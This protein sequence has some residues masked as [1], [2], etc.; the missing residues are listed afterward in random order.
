MKFAIV[1]LAAGVAAL[2]TL[3]VVS[4]QSDLFHTSSLA[5]RATTASDLGLSAQL[6]RL[7][8]TITSTVVH[9]FA[10]LDKSIAKIVPKTTVLSW[11]DV[12]NA[13]RTLDVWQ[14]LRVICMAQLYRV[15][16]SLVGDLNA[17]SELLGVSE[18]MAS[19][20]PPT[21]FKHHSSM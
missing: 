19:R 7:N 1:F 13:G 14:G 12:L 4:A 15:I 8:S 17:T 9:Y 3:F 21:H 20:R 18:N 2:G 10:A 16:E 11:L 6:T 5:E